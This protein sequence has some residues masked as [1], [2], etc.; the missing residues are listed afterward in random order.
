[1]MKKGKTLLAVLLMLISV[2][3]SASVKIVPEPVEIHEYSGK[4]TLPSE[5]T[6]SDF[7]DGKMVDTYIELSSKILKTKGVALKKGGKNST[8]KLSI[9]KKIK[10]EGEY[11]IEVGK[12]DIRIQAADEDA[13]WCGL[14]TLTQLLSQGVDRQM[15]IRDEPRFGYRGAMLDCCRHFFSVKDVKSFIDM[16]AVHKLN[17][18]HWHLT[19]DQGWRI[20]IKKYPRL[21]EIGSV[22]ESTY[23]TNY[24]GEQCDSFVDKPYGGF[25][26]QD[27]IREIV[28]YAQDRH[29]VTI[30]EIE[31]PGHSVAALA[32]YPWL[33]CTGGPYKVRV[34]WGI[35]EDVMCI[36]KETTWQFIRDV[37][38]EVC[39]L[40]P[41]ELIHIGGDETPRKKWSEC[42]D[43]QALMKKEGMT[44]E[45]QLQSWI[46]TKVE[47]Y[48]ETKGKRI[49]GWDEVL[50]GGVSTKCVVMSWLKGSVGGQKAAGL[51]NDVIMTDKYH[52][53]FDCYQ[54]DT[55]EGELFAHKRNIPLEKVW[56]YNP[57]G[58]MDDASASHVLGVQCNT[59]TEHISSMD[60]VYFMNLPRMAALAEVA[61]STPASLSGYQDF[62]QRLQSSL[63]PIY[64]AAGWNFAE[65]Y[66]K[67]I[68]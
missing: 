11:I 18:F 61:W 5:V 7:R 19:E 52:C 46:T 57:I 27:D 1:M 30:P 33:G 25:Y 24:S 28:K 44:E 26:T 20:E 67:D 68:K 8:V 53:Y 31:I 47:N 4:F 17:R 60:R 62:L 29:I 22:R 41:G 12:R 39:Q 3:A 40:F 21:T 48:L 56:S 13:L 42:P 37:L 50:E 59:W 45:A 43:C 2:V 32:S 34:K 64:Q 23:M 63:I 16:M 49:I 15:V 38:D 55:R 6:I 54:T 10:G 58:G 65:F 51:G 35:S 14:Q 9:S 36:G 66:K